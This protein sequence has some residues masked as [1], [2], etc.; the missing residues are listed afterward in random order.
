[1]DWFTQE[2]YIRC[3]H[4]LG[5]GLRSNYGTWTDNNKEGI[6]KF[7]T[8]SEI[9]SKPLTPI[10]QGDAILGVDCRL[11][12]KPVWFNLELGTWLSTVVMSITRPWKSTRQPPLEVTWFLVW[13]AG[14]NGLGLSQH[15][16]EHMYL[17]CIKPMV[18]YIK[19]V[20][21]KAENMNKVKWFVRLQQ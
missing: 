10:V 13:R 5:R 2:P 16:T 15:R 9:Q 11:S 4:I 7:R 3:C 6:D 1:M 19:I 12:T 20:L 8:P 14:V 18:K 21:P 17:I